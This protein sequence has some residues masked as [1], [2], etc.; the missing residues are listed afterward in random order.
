V[1]SYCDPET[2]PAVELVMVGAVASHEGFFPHLKPSSA[3]FETAK[4]DWVVRPTS[5]FASAQQ[6]VRAERHSQTG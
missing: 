1:V 3:W 6:T 2:L 4:L 5:L